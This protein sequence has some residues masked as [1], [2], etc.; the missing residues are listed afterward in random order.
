MAKLEPE[1]RTAGELSIADIEAIVAIGRQRAGLL[2]D[3]RTALEACD[4]LRAL[5]VARVLVGLERQAGEH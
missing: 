1:F 4:D 5:S 2:D 3:L